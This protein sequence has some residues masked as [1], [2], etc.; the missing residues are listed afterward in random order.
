MHLLFS[1]KVDNLPPCNNY[2][3]DK[4]E[5][6][7]KYS[8][9]AMFIVIWHYQNQTESERRFTVTNENGS[10]CRWELFCQEDSESCYL[11]RTSFDLSLGLKINKW[12]PSNMEEYLG[13]AT[14]GAVTAMKRFFV[15]I[16]LTVLFDRTSGINI[17]YRTFCW[18]FNFRGIL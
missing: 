13:L 9:F 7:L 11:I 1:R 12:F 10:R 17:F 15:L 16:S 6:F 8:K 3:V 14:L 4:Q 5:P 18:Q 2:F